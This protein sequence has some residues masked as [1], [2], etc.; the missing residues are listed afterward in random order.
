MSEQT[1]EESLQNLR[2]LTPNLPPPKLEGPGA[3][4]N[5]WNAWGQY[6]LRSLE[7]HDE[8][9]CKIDSRTDDLDKRLYLMEFKSGLIAL[10]VGLVGGLL[11]TILWLAKT[12]L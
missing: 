7:R 5:G 1:P 10:L 9:L 6:V 11:G 2:E 12:S 8:L 4:P 3:A